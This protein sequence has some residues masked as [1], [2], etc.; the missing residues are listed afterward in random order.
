MDLVFTPGIKEFCSS[1]LGGLLRGLLKG[2]ERLSKICGFLDERESQARE[3][4]KAFNATGKK[5]ICPQ[6]FM[7]F[8]HKSLGDINGIQTP[9][10]AAKL[11]RVLVV[12]PGYPSIYKKCFTYI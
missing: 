1:T 6:N 9:R 12:P 8:C 10:R 3:S 7:T 2:L 5:G 11:V 4:C